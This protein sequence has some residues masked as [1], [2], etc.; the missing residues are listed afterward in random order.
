LKEGEL[1]E[2]SVV[3]NY[4]TTAADR[5]KYEVTFYSLEMILAI[6]FRVRSKRGTQ[7]RIWANRNLRE[8]MVKGFVMDDE[9]LKNPD[10]RPD[11]FD[12]LLE[13]IRDIRASEKRFYQKLRDLFALSSDYDSTDK[14]TQMFFAE[15]QNKLLYAVT[16]KTA[17]EIIVSRADASKPNMALTSWKGSVVR[18]QDI[19]IAKN[20]LNED[21]IDTLNRLVVIFL[22]SAEL[23]AKNRIDITM[24]F[25]YENVDRILEFQDKNILHNAGT[26]SNKQ[27]EAKVREIY[28]HYDK[29]RKEHDALEADKED[30]EE[31]KQL[32]EKI[33]KHDK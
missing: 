16:G 27:M 25:W 3:K 8:Y 5:K 4:F 32:E 24:K 17:A 15:T 33:K 26:I 29:R 18:K 9:R 1:S 23:R 31:L 13:R 20:Y 10:G 30:M 14:T 28:A 11:Y 6:G 7:F 22:E 21:E 19:F 12:E 2:A